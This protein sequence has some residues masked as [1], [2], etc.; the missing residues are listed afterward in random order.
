MLPGRYDVLPGTVVDS[1]GATS[2]DVDIVVMNS[3]WFPKVK[4]PAAAGSR[5]Q[6]L[7]FEGVYAVGE[8]KQTLGFES[9]DSA[10]AKLVRC[11][12]LRRTPVPRDRLT[13]NRDLEACPHGLSNPLY[14]FVIGATS[15]VDVQALVER[16]F[17]INRQ[18]RRLEVV[19]AMCILGKGTVT[20]AFRAP[21]G[22]K[23]ALF[24]SEDLQRPLAPA[25]FPNE[26]CESPFFVLVE[27]L[28]LHLYNSVLGPEDIASRYGP[29]ERG[30]RL[31][32]ERGI[33]LP[34]DD[35]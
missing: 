2:G 11:H 10:M 13:E 9:L 24:M 4:A 16:F 7:P 28:M 34:P 25:Y 8:V 23:P 12:R 1:T 5:R 17:D 26:V 19:R 14:S 21:D 31:P 18:L 15:V 29:S 20:W 32:S 22:P 30:V 35:G 33:I 3:T 27:N 6:L